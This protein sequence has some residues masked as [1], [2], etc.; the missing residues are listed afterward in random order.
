ML[1]KGSSGFW[2]GAPGNHHQRI[3]L[4]PAARISQHQLSE[5]VLAEP[6][7][8]QQLEALVAVPWRAAP[9]A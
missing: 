1:A 5:L 7:S 9:E 6:S 8:W 2:S 3:Q 4:L